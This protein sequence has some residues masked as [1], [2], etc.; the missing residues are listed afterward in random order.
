MPIPRKIK[1]LRVVANPFVHLNYEG[2]PTAGF[3][4]DPKH[5]NPDRIPVGY[6]RKA[7]VREARMPVTFDRQRGTVS[8]DAR[9]SV[10]DIWFEFSS[11]PQTIVDLLDHGPA[12][13]YYKQKAKAGPGEIAP[14]LLPADAASAK[15]LGVPFRDPSV[16]VVETARLAAKAWAEEHDGELPD[17]ALPDA[18]SEKSTATVQK[19]GADGVPVL[20]ADGKPITVPADT[21]LHPSHLAAARL[22]AAHVKKLPKTTSTSA[23]KSSA[24]ETR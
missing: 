5:E 24:M 7:L 11:E 16:V 1:R 21:A 22:L 10:H 14:A 18:L 19:L 6:T 23:P 20:G 17:W 2:V 8:G 15:R 9:P 4:L 12:A 3:T 13:T